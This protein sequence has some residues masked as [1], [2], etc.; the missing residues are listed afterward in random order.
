[1]AYDPAGHSTVCHGDGIAPNG[2]GGILLHPE[3]GGGMGR[4]IAT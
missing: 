4:H 1:M 2:T 3:R